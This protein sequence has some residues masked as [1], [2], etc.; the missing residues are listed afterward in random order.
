M[1]ST[2]TSDAAV[3][4]CPVNGPRHSPVATV[5][6]PDAEVNVTVAVDSA[7]STSALVF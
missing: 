4:V 7:M 3:N 6:P 2:S 1:W 5:Q